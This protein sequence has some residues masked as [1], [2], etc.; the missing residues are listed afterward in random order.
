MNK[1]IVIGESEYDHHTLPKETTNNLKKAEKALQY[2]KLKKPEYTW[3][4]RLNPRT[5][6]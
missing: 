2:W 1:Y 4:I 6:T 5:H 3:R